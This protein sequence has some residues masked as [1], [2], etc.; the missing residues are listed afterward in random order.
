[1]VLAPG[2]SLPPDRRFVRPGTGQLAVLCCFFNPCGYRTPV[3]NLRTFRESLARQG[4]PLYLLEL[5]IGDQPFA[6]EP[7][8]GV[9]QLRSPTILFHKER[10]LNALLERVPRSFDLLAWVDGDLIF[11]Q[12][13]W[14]RATQE[15]LEHFPIVQLFDRAKYLD[16]AGH[17]IETRVGMAA[18]VDS[19]LPDFRKFAVY[20]PGFAW[21]A[22]REWWERHKLFDL[23]V[24]GS[25]DSDMACGFYGWWEHPHL[26]GYHPAMR[27]AVLAW[28]QQVW[29][30][31][32]GRVGYVPGVVRHLWHGSLVDRQY[33]WRWRAFSRFQY[34]PA[35]DLRAG[36]HGL[37]EW[38][39]ANPIFEQGVREY[40]LAR[41]EDA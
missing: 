11:E 32:R 12:D 41:R 36:A 18:A 33:V 23:N 24:L 20:H 39:G 21:A 15:R 22:R 19:R 28:G 1:M 17:T 13:G 31:V 14:V 40:F 25:G 38:T 8:E 9:V 2:L 35:R 37:W 29:H 34:Q 10:L 7:S 4:V 16:K 26:T 30:D 5:A 3:K 27:Q 6:L